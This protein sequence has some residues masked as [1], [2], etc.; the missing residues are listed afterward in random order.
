MHASTT[1]LRDGALAGTGAIGM[2][3]DVQKLLVLDGHI[4]QHLGAVVVCKLF[5]VRVRELAVA[6]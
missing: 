2:A 4:A 6:K 1:S 3:A 5:L